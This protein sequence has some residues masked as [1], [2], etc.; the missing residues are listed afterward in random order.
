[1]V[2]PANYLFLFSPLTYCV[3]LWSHG[4]RTVREPSS[5]WAFVDLSPSAAESLW[6][7]PGCLL[8]LVWGL[9]WVGLWLW[10]SGSCWDFIE[11]MSLLQK[12]SWTDLEST[13]K[14]QKMKCFTHLQLFSCIDV[15]KWS[16]YIFYVPLDVR[17]PSCPRHLLGE[18]LNVFLWQVRLYCHQMYEGRSAQGWGP[19]KS[20]FQCPALFPL[21]S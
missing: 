15:K 16:W 8:A 4:L 20:C 6:H 3:C 18:C 11:F 10:R 21:N 14:I 7:S 1:M 19:G 9:N 5:S 2:H 13:H 17:S 12:T